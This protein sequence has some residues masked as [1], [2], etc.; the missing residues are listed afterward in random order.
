MNE[1][2][3][4]FSEITDENR[5]TFHFHGAPKDKPLTAILVFPADDRAATILQGRYRVSKTGQA[6]ATRKVVD[7]LLGFV[8]QLKRFFDAN[9]LLVTVATGLFL[10]LI[11]AL[12]LRVRRAELETLHR[13]GCARGTIVKMVGVELAIVIGAGI[14]IALCG[15]LALIAWLGP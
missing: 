6:L 14:V 4:K 10:A 12:T 3:V 7:E 11:V 5:D 15:S 2:I 1:E 9:T 8:F 13:I